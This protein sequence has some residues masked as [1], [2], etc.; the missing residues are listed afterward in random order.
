MEALL[1]SMLATGI[2]ELGD[3]TQLLVLV[4]AARFR[5]PVLLAAGMATAFLCT[6][7]LA[8][9]GGV[10][11]ERLLT[12]ERSAWIV[13]PGFLVMALWAWFSRSHSESEDPRPAGRGRNAFLAALGVFFVMEL[14]DK[15]QVATVGLAIALE[16]VWLVIAG[17]VAGATIVNLPVIWLGNRLDPEMR[18]AW[19][20]K[21]AAGLFTGIGLWVLLH[22]ALGWV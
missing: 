9:A 5:R 13:G 21:I 17:A 8:A 1:I 16:P 4:L 12:P 6:H 3:K 11:L 2:A 19:F 18:F 20:R 22:G 10:W 14:G 15:S 7:I